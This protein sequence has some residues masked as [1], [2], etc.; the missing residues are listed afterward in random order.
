MKRTSLLFA[1]CALALAAAAVPARPVITFTDSD[2]EVLTISK[3]ADMAEIPANTQ[4]T[5][6]SD[7]ATQI[8]C[9]VS[10]F[11]Y[12]AAYGMG[13]YYVYKTDTFDAPYTERTTSGAG[14]DNSTATTHF[15]GGRTYTFY[16]LDAN[17]NRSEPLEFFLRVVG[18][19]DSDVVKADDFTLEADGDYHSISTDLNTT[20]DIYSQA[21]VAKNASGDFVLTNDE[22][23]KSGFVVTKNNTELVARRMIIEWG[24]G[25][26]ENQSAI[27]LYGK[28]L[29]AYTDA[30]ELYDESTQGEL[31]GTITCTGAT[32]M[33]TLKQSSERDFIGIKAVGGEVAIKSIRVI[34]I[35]A[36]PDEPELVGGFPEKLEAGTVL[37]WRLNGYGSIYFGMES[38][39]SLSNW[40]YKYDSVKAVYKEV[41]YTVPETQ[42]AATFNIYAYGG[43]TKWSTMCIKYAW[44][45]AI[46]DNG[47]V[48][49]VEDIDSDN[50]AEAEYYNLQ[51]VRVA[52]DDLTPGIYIRR[53]GSSV[54]KVAIR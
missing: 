46:G 19:V 21:M 31:L 2:G 6:T 20:R 35:Y 39:M 30:S 24:D 33:I 43:D 37:T 11:N 50:D 9:S 28:K 12:L 32:D 8:E 53:Q 27:Q 17:G 29:E 42:S 15:L 40:S 34:W 23:I 47:N 48:S 26:V 41:S 10:Y 36:V 7:G 18:D 22:S 51:G 45:Y 25:C 38:G 54:T 5:I 16:G 44:H 14:D 13:D 1:S 49:G 3:S 52:A 4:L